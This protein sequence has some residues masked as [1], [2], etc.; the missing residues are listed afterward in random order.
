MLA[1]DSDT[2]GDLLLGATR[3]DGPAHG[4][5]AFERA[6]APSPTHRTPNFSGTDTFTYKA[7]D[8]RARPA[9]PRRSPSP[10]PR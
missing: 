3:V 6:T 7:N 8:G 1:N 4:T 2:E 9:R 5:L 10:S